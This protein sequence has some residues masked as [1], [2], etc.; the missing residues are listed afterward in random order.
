MRT[1]TSPPQ[2][3]GIR[4]ACSSYPGNSRIQA[5][6][7]IALSQ[8][9]NEMNRDTFLKDTDVADFIKWL[10]ETLPHLTVTLNIPESRRFVPKGVHAT[11]SGIEQVLPHYSWMGTWT[12][13]KGRLGGLA[14][15]LRT[16]LATGNEDDTLRA[17]L[18]ILNWGGVRGAVSYLQAK[19]GNDALKAYL[20]GRKQLFDL[21]GPQRLRDLNAGVIDKFDAGMTKIYSLL[22]TTGSPIYDSR[23][24]AAMA[25]LYQYHLR[26]SSKQM[27]ELLNFPS[28]SARGKQVRNPGR[29]G[30]P[31]YDAPQFY[32]RSVQ[33]HVWAQFQLKLGWIIQEIL[34]RT[35][36]FKE[37][38]GPAIADRS[39]AF[40]ACL[41]MIGYDLKSMASN[42]CCGSTQVTT[43]A[44]IKQEVASATNDD[45][46]EPKDTGWVPTSHPF[47]E[48]L[49]HFLRF[50]QSQQPSYELQDFKGWLIRNYTK[51][52]GDANAEI[53][54]STAYGYLF[55][56]RAQEFDLVDRSIEDLECI[57]EGGEQGLEC[58]VRGRILNVDERAWVCLVDAWIVGQLHNVKSTQRRNK[59]LSDAGFAGTPNASNTLFLVGRDVGKHF[60]LL[61]DDGSRTAFYDEFFETRMVMDEELETLN[62]A[63]QAVSE[64]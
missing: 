31:F 45:L 43:P 58:A 13:N 7:L 61:N 25:M 57:V 28:G 26:S 53:K 42:A 59:I 55:P 3:D 4:L 14:S 5:I 39:R 20:H 52:R 37:T 35:N 10:I 38:E 9:Q 54:L 44:S 41:F 16:A 32:T 36:W 56:L 46:E 22:D 18:E 50:R 62:N 17:C 30:H 23:V 21:T 48:V 11:C 51:R 33:P 24:G 8:K 12:H 6:P 2:L 29:L 1:S 49:K 64:D 40:E 47:T 34:S 15:D 27:T 60:R 63:R 19:A